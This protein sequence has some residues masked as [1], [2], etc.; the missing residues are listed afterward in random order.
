MRQAADRAARAM[1]DDIL[2]GRLPAGVRI[3]AEDVAR[4]LEVSRTPVREALSRL[5]AE[6][7]VELS[8][9]RGARVAS[10]TTEE[11]R[12]I[13][14]LRLQLEPYAVSQ[15]VPRLDAGQ[16][17]QLD[18]LAAM[19]QRTAAA[20]PDR[21]WDA[22][23]EGNR[24]FHGLLIQVAGNP[25]VAAALTSVTHIAVV[26]QNY[27]HYS[28]DALARSMSHHVEIIEAARAGD[29]DWAESVMRSHLFN[30]RA[31]MLREPGGAGER[32]GSGEQPEAER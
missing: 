20:G 16:L 17:E 9:N 32:P 6:G 8:P 12:E 11:L 3:A 4:Q 1:R 18:E 15:A 14:D 27:R 31:T 5:A 24:R 13:F 30:A 26:R 29:P 23:V 25:P 10:W 7:L 22:I 2:S 19:M 21:D 28:P